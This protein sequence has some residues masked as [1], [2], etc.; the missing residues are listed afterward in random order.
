MAGEH[1]RTSQPDGPEAEVA[2]E[3]WAPCRLCGARAD[4]RNRMRLLGRYDVR[5]YVCSECGSLETEEPYWLDDAYGATGIGDDV[6]AGQRTIDLVL[7]TSAL[8]HHLKIPGH[9][10]CIDFGGGIGLFTRLMRDRGFNFA[11]YDRYAQPFFSDRHSLSSMAGRSPAV[12]TAFEVLEHFPN[13]AQDLEQLFGGHP[14][15]VIA[16]TELFTGQDESWFYLGDGTGQHVF[17]YSPR[18][19]AG[20]ARRFGYALAVVGGLIV[21]LERSEIEQLGIPSGQAL[22]VLKALSP[23]DVLMRHALAL[24]MKH[25]KAPYEHIMREV[26]AGQ[27]A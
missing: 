3:H 21:F 20:I 24:F 12:V 27:S 1:G 22:A 16:T 14:A 6:G 13:P 15:L 4:F 8:L 19:I 10:E 18:A 25:Q 9:A 11:S 26:E 17:F 23:P 7:K 5:Y 2:A